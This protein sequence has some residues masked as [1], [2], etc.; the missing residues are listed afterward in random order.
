MK[1]SAKVTPPKRPSRVVSHS[2]DYFL[3]FAKINFRKRPQLYR[4]GRGEQG[5][6]LVEP[7]KSEILPHWRF[8]DEAKAQASSE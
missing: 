2:F 7:Y 8:A 3:D 4:I 5:V 1:S 6:L